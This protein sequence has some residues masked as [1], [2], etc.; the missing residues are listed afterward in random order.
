MAGV[1][2]IDLTAARLGDRADRTRV[3]MGIDQACRDIGFFTVAG[4]GVSPM[5]VQ[6]LREAAHAFF[7]L[8]LD[9]KRQAGHPVAGTPR[10]Y[11][12]LAGET[13]ARA[14]DQIAPP[15]LKE[16]YHVGP[17]DV[18]PEPYFTGERGR[19]FFLP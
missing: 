4:P 3:A 9:E 17:V 12:T 7:A 10:G 16:F 18:G 13:L 19:Q 6:D 5:V 11:H 2:L 8:P 1:P 14:N 15:D